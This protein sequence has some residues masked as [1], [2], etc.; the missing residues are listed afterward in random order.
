MLRAAV[1]SGSELGRRSSELM[2][3]GKLVSDEI[4]ISLVKERLSQVFNN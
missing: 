3:S 2:H 1:K 4:I